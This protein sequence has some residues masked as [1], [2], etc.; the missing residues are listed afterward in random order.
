MIV[1]TA[2]YFSVGFATWIAI[3]VQDREFSTVTMGI[4]HGIFAMMIWTLISITQ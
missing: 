3:G 2:I 1:L 4:L